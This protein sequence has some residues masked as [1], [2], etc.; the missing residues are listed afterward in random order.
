MGIS[1]FIFAFGFTL[2]FS[3]IHLRGKT[4]AGCIVF[5]CAYHV[6]NELSINIRACSTSLNEESVNSCHAV[7]QVISHWPIT[8]EAWSH[9]PASPHGIYGGQSDTWT[10]FSSRFLVFPVSI[11]HS[12]IY[13]TSMLLHMQHQPLLTFIHLSL[14]LCNITNWQHW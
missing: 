5:V 2:T 13:C 6:W 3:G 12:F 4:R 11:I 8:V 1:F 14:I 7:C 9:F 10:G